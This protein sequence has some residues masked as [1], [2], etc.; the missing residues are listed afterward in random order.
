[1]THKTRSN[2]LMTSRERVLAAM[3]RQPVDHLP[4]CVETLCHGFVRFVTERLPSPFERATYYTG[5]GLD[6]GISLDEAVCLPDANPDIRVKSWKDQP[7]GEPH[8][9]MGQ[10]YQT[11][12]GT[13]RQVVVR[14]DDYE[15]DYFSRGR[16]TLDLFSDYHVPAHRSRQYLVEK[17][18][19]LAALSCL[20]R[21]V[22]GPGLKAYREKAR[23][24]RA[25]CDQHQLTL[26]VY[27]L[28]V[29]DPII[30]MSGVERTLQMAMEEK[31]LFRRYVQLVADWQRQ[32]LE[33]ALDAGARH[34]VRRGLYESTDFWSPM[35][36]EEFLFEPLRQETAIAHAAGATV[37]YVM[38][39]GYMPLL[40][41]V[42]NARVDML[43]N[44]DPLAHG[45][46][47]RAI[48]AA[49]GDAVAL[50][51]GVN[52]YLVLEK[53]SETDV[54]RAVREAIA[55][56]TPATGCILAPSDCILSYDDAAVAER[57]FHVMIDT[58][59]EG[60]YRSATP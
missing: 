43:S 58:W 1:M 31:D 14:T 47:M 53:G 52:N 24:A 11:S 56:F 7:P 13:L 45:T 42:R 32:V 50:C 49:V 29:G 26:A 18:A 2:P 3:R 33:I 30:W 10:E 15:S 20:L 12:K 59:R 17:E 54:R 57:N 5:L 28:G 21:P 8:P 34:V 35:L 44:L 48:R 40:D 60:L 36:F 19:D 51:G 27:Q 46:D 39:S 4:L 23:Q 9:L 16:E 22:S 38:L 6:A 55:A 41:L 25:F 37:D